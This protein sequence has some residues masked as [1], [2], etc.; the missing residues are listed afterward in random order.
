MSRQLQLRLLQ[1]CTSA[2]LLRPRRTRSLCASPKRTGHAA[3]PRP[4]PIGSAGPAHSARK[5]DVTTGP[6][7]TVGRSARSSE[8]RNVAR[9]SRQQQPPCLTP[10]ITPP[11]LSS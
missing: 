7:V 11:R 9:S 3:G 2:R 4:P 8:R 10:P 1:N 5:L 6:R